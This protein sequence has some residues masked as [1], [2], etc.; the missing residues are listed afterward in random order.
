V[1][2]RLADAYLANPGGMSD[3]LKAQ[4]LGVFEPAEV[5]ELSIKLVSWLQNK[6]M[7]ALGH[8]GR[9]ADDRIVKFHY[10]GLGGRT[11]EAGSEGGRPREPGDFKLLGGT[12]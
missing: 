8:D 11:L 2:L 3:E 5:V 10:D 7:I 1:A 12:R 4:V 9:A 6:A